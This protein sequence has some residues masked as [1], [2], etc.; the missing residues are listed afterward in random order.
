MPFVPRLFPLPA[1][2]SFPRQ[3]RNN[4]AS[5]RHC[6]G[7][8]WSPA[9]RWYRPLGVHLAHPPRHHDHH[10][11]HHHHYDRKSS[12]CPRKI[13]RRVCSR[14]ASPSMDGTWVAPR[15]KAYPPWRWHH[16]RRRRRRRPEN[17][18]EV[19][20]RRKHA[21]RGCHWDSVRATPW[22]ASSSSVSPPTK[23][24]SQIAAPIPLS[25]RR[26]QLLHLGPRKAGRGLFRRRPNA[27]A[28]ESSGSLRW[29]HNRNA[30]RARRK[31]AGAYDAYCTEP[32]LTTPLVGEATTQ[33]AQ[34]TRL[35]SKTTTTKTTLGSL[36]GSPPL[37]Q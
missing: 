7:R 5:H 30:R 19:L 15:K 9:G 6:G 34:S 3:Y 18:I 21:D 13:H 17:V 4:A 31:H 23:R 35:R 8:P 27:K 16:P 24:P 29:L 25:A 2:T 32:A 26:R 28:R 20:Q 37:L 11:H 36:L 14:T 10:D 12:Y 33:A 1:S 22:S